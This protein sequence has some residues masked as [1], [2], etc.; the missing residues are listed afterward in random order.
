MDL[1]QSEDIDYRAYSILPTAPLLDVC[2]VCKQP[3]LTDLQSL[4]C[5][6][7]VP[8]HGECITVQKHQSKP[9]PVCGEHW[10]QYENT[11]WAL[12]CVGI[13]VLLCVLLWVFFHYVV[14]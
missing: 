12:Y 5:R 10:K 3:V 7:L 1:S 11:W 6:C 9:C 8:A 4:P 14:L 13:I 2:F